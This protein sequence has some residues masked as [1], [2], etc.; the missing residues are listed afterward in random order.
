M[1]WFLL[2]LF[3]FNILCADYTNYLSV[4]AVFKNEARF[5]KEWVEFHRIVGAEKFYLYNND[6]T[7]DYLFVL[8][9]YIDAGIVEL[10]DWPGSF[11]ADPHVQMRAYQD[12]I[13][14]SAGVTRWL[15][16]IDTDEFVFP[17]QHY[18]LAKFLRGYEKYAGVCPNWQ[19]YGHSNVE[20]IPT[21]KLMIECLI[22]KAAKRYTRNTHIKS[23][24]QPHF[25]ETCDNPHFCI[26]KPGHTQV[27]ANKAP[28]VGPQSP[29]VE[30][31]K[32]RINHYWSRDIT[33][34]WETKIGRIEA[35]EE[36]LIPLNATIDS[37]KEI[38]KYIKLLRQLC[39]CTPVK[40]KK[41]SVKT[42]EKW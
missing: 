2:F 20:R 26:Y 14:R 40:A 25:V 42:S 37:K 11:H 16:I 10:T 21:D 41:S 9:P 24:V 6:S 23:I 7:D 5:L 34:F 39:H 27:T 38:F 35:S 22:M 19:L 32:V 36:A 12:A 1:Y 28:F 17:V 13:K 3:S 18:S 8:Q 29:S 4:C 31:D 30:V 15:A 33:F